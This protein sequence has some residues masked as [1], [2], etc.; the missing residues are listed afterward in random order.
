M[1]ASTVTLQDGAFEVE[2][3]QA[4]TGEHMLWLHGEAGPSWT[5][6]HDTLAQRWHVLAPSHPGYG[7]STGGDKLDDITR[8]KCGEDDA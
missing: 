2:L 8:E 7:A 6:F 4:G 5:A 3:R 1:V